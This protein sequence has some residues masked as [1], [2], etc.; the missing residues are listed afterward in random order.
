[1]Q[2]YFCLAPVTQ[3]KL[4][5][6]AVLA[7]RSSSQHFLRIML[8]S[9]S[10][11]VSEFRGHPGVILGSS[12]AHPGAIFSHPGIILGHH[13]VIMGLPGVILGSCWVILG[14]GGFIPGS[15]LRPGPGPLLGP[16]A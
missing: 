9:L 8:I 15:S 1:M 4:T 3:Q 7:Q 11:C 12:L 13:G 14:Q 2:Q 16:I 10:L 6:E 5:L